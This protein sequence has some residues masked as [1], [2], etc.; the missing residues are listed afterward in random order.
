MGLR[1]RI[2]QTRDHIARSYP[3]AAYGVPHLLSSSPFS[4]V[5]WKAHGFNKSRAPS[6]LFYKISFARSF[7]TATS[8][9]DIWWGLG[10]NT[11]DP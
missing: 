7:Y 10:K 5:A 4:S 3:A 9:S 11:V 2:R 1:F 8:F 6:F